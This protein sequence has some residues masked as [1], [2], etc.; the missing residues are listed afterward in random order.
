MFQSKQL[1]G[2]IVV[3]LFLAGCAS[4]PTVDPDW[5]YD[6]K[7][8]DKTVGVAGNITGLVRLSKAPTTGA[9]AIITEMLQD[10]S[11]VVVGNPRNFAFLD[12]ATGEAIATK[13]ED[14]FNS[15]RVSVNLK[16]TSASG[17][18]ADTYVLLT[19]DKARTLLV[20][21]YQYGTETVTALDIDSGEELWRSNQFKYSFEKYRPAVNAVSRGLL[22]PLARAI[23]RKNGGKT[24]V[25][26]PTLEER[27]TDEYKFVR[28]LV[29]PTADGSA[30]YFKTFEGVFL[31]DAKSGKVHW[32]LPGFQGQALSQ[33]IE[34]PDGDVLLLSGDSV[35]LTGGSS[36]F[37]HHLAR[38]HG[39]S[40][41]LRWM[42]EQS[43]KWV[44]GMT[45]AGDHI[46]VAASPLQVFHLKSGKKLWENDVHGFQGLEVPL[47]IVTKNAVYVYGNT[48]R[49]SDRKVH[50][51]IPHMLKKHELKT[52]KV[53]WESDETKSRIDHMQLHGDRL[54]LSG[55]GDWFG[56]N[57]GL[58]TFD[59]A[60]GKLAWKSPQFENLPFIYR[61]VDASAP[62]VD[63]DTVF[64]AG[65][66]TLY[67]FALKNGEPR[68]TRDLQGHGVGLTQGVAQTA[69]HVVVVSRQGVI[70]LRK[71]GEAAYTIKLPDVE[72][73]QP[74]H[75]Y[76]MLR[77]V[78]RDN[79]ISIVDLA[80]GSCQTIYYPI[81][82]QPV[83]GALAGWS[84]VTPDGRHVLALDKARELKRYTVR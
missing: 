81:G 26:E 55:A 38:V 57:G 80:S 4:K 45:V 30:F 83:L 35:F 78:K 76:L 31:V 49:E 43:G 48:L 73:I 84:T 69:G 5:R 54:L 61:G 28:N 72:S 44:N 82:E 60:N 52:G 77:H 70:G 75:D 1:L 12:G 65:P 8:L 32:S 67:A 16:V 25:I 19:L 62:L 46:V 36:M 22:E 34:L 51:G 24:E 21:D 23:D 15:I 42:S 18:A 64:I 71:D 14:F 11:R 59:A 29:V 2:V 39:K 3:A 58:L 66:K 50:L 9:A 40:G 27:L 47:P 74:G 6:S 53:L 20:F 68:F 41:K 7:S 79:G 10:G 63:G 56:G 37:T 33:V 13:G 17:F